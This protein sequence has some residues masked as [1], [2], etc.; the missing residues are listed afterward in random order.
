M[1]TS[2]HD[3]HSNRN[4]DARS[5]VQSQRSQASSLGELKYSENPNIKD[6]EKLVADFSKNAFVQLN[7][8]LREQPRF[9]REIN[10]KDEPDPLGKSKT[11]S[12]SVDSSIKVANGRKEIKGRKPAKSRSINKKDNNEIG[13]TNNSKESLDRNDANDTDNHEKLFNTSHYDF[14]LN[15]SSAEN[16]PS[17]ADTS[18]LNV[19]IDD[20]DVNIRL[21]SDIDT[22]DDVKKLADQEIVKD[23]FPAGFEDKI[24]KMRVGHAQ[25]LSLMKD[26]NAALAKKQ[27]PQYTRN[28]QAGNTIEPQDMLADRESHDKGELPMLTAYF[29][30]P[31]DNNGTDDVANEQKYVEKLESILYQI[32][33]ET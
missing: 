17:T 19:G 22:L 13:T 20:P 16:N 31:E 14:N 24:V 30:L 12:K 1:D 29:E 23:G 5:K 4:D 7:P 33:D 2:S 32:K 6:I 26:R 11:S 27:L 25:L 28:R 9:I 18:A 21:W 15:E 10:Q 8:K 3:S